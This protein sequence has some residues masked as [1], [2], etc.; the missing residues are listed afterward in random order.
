V[1]N[2]ALLDRLN[3]GLAGRYTIERELGE[4]G[5]ATVYLARDLRHGRPVALK[6]LPPQFARAVGVERFQREIQ[7]AAG[8][9]HP[10]ILTVHDS[11]E[12]DGLL[13]YV[14]PFV[15][16]ES[17]RA[18]LS[19]EGRLPLATA[20]GIAQDVLSALEYAHAR[21]IV[22]RD[23]KPENI[24]L[25]AG[26]AVVADFGI[27]RAIGSPEVERLTET[28]LALGTPAYMSPE[29]VSGATD[30]DG[31]S[32]L[33]SLACVL[34]EMLTGK[35][36]FIAGTPFAV[37]VKRLTEPAPPLPRLSGVPAAV[38]QALR[39]ALAT[40]PKDRFPT[41]AAF[42]AAL[43]GAPRLRGGWRWVVG[44]VA[45]TLAALILVLGGMSL[46][47]SDLKA[48]VRTVLTRKQAVANPRRI[49]VAPFANRTGDSAYAALG[50]MAAEWIARD[51]IRTGTF[52]VV[53]P[54]TALVNARVVAAIP[55][56]LRSGDAGVAL[57]EESGA[58]MVVTGS[59]YRYGDSLRITAQVTDLATG[60]LRAIEP[61][62]GPASEPSALVAALARHTAGALVS[63]VDTTAVALVQPPSY[64][65]YR[66]ASRAWEEF[67][68]DE[69]S[70]FYADIDRAVAFDP[71]YVGALLLK[72]YALHEDFFWAAT[73]STVRRVEAHRDL[74]GPGELAGLDYF[75]AMLRGDL[76]GAARAAHRVLAY[77]PGSA[78]VPLLAARA[79]IMADRPQDAL[80]ALSYTDPTRG[81]NLVNPSW[82]AARCAA[83]H[84]LGRH[85]EE[86]V[87]ARR[88]VRQFPPPYAA[89][90]L[91]EQALAALG[92]EDELVNLLRHDQP[93]RN[94]GQVPLPH[95][96]LYMARELAAHG[97]G[98]AASRVVAELL[99]QPGIL[100][101]DTNRETERFQA[102]LLYE[103]GRWP[104]SEAIATRLHALDPDSI[105]YQGLLAVAAA[106]AGDS[107]VARRMDSTL[108]RASGPY[109]FGHQLYWRARIAAA[110]GDKEGAV[111]LLREALNEG[112]PVGTT[113]ELFL[114]RD[115][116]LRGLPR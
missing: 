103:A 71:T 9:Q 34:F 86:L 115:P 6:L 1:L 39:R 92:R 116:D 89:H 19:R 65:A 50:E 17:L 41:A 8:L 82:W 94:V 30:V 21:G 44:G 105:D 56:V 78:E 46:V 24:L 36:P 68:R 45:A 112:Q 25:S 57:A 35:P 77:S 23:I 81:L 13:Y 11:G 100:A 5:M 3:A 18:R 7:L 51:L 110:E 114:H 80:E 20:L 29:Q 49:V 61:V 38:D 64:E 93:D 109:L 31:R 106:R 83:L 54:R 91:E 84:Q 47:P 70:A 104:E 69:D 102:E 53:D 88:A 67:M 107:A 79:D 85:E 72:A 111:R 33:Y 10:H 73:D 40:S 108:A 113:W 98:A 48:L 63:S 28:G 4:G 15:E 12:A 2:P 87:A 62:G 101:A 75:Q 43:A 26:E 58:G 90:R 52:E 74:L 76:A 14:M 16:G 99:A 95:Q 27:A 55:R 22:H 97:Y 96:W 42:S 37:A 59:V 32:D 60:A 66:V